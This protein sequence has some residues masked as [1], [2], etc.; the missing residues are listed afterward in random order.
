MTRQSERRCVVTGCSG[1]AAGMIRFVLAPDGQVTPDL[2]ERLPGR[3]IWLSAR[4][5]VVNTACAKHAF[6]RAARA[7]ATADPALADRIEGL[8]AD[9]CVALLGLARRAGM[10]VAG[11]EKVKARLKDGDVALVLAARDG[12]TDG[13]AKIRALAGT[14]PIW[15]VLT[16]NEIG[17]AFG[18]DHA[19]HVAIARGGLADRLSRD[20]DRLQ[21]FR[22]ADVAPGGY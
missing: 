18:R 3:G 9:R 10:A 5:D 14:V 2:E 20:L 21:G 13:R 22:G 8:L 12:A 7:K 19:V 17:A 16:A 6:A 15:A 11:F 4:R 1:P